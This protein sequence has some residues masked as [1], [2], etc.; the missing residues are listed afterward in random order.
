[1]KAMFTKFKLMNVSDRLFK[2]MLYRE[3]SPV[4]IKYQNSK[5][6]EESHFSKKEGAYTKIGFLSDF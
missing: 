2:A 6:R 1:M 4:F 3:K 5:K